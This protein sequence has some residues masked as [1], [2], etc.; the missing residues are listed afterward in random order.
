[1]DTLVSRAVGIFTNEPIDIYVNPTFIPAVLQK[2]YDRLW[3]PARMKAIV[4]GLAANGIA[5]EINNRYRIP[6]AA[7]VR[8]AKQAGVKFA[9]GTNNTGAADLG[10]NEYCIEMIRECGLQPE[11]FWMPPGDGKKAVQRKPLVR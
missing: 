1:M 7:F 4:D 3:T 2:D 11:H 9:C 5:M 10:R 6:S 8:L